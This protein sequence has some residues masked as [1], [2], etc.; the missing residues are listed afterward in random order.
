MAESRLKTQYRIRLCLKCF[1]FSGIGRKSFRPVMRLP[2]RRTGYESWRLTMARM[3]IGQAIDIHPLE[4]GRPLV[5][6]GVEI[7]SPKGL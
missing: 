7:D 2:M 3:R 4:S 1:S 5:L 6:G